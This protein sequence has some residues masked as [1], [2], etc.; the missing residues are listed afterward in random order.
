V[1]FLKNWQFQYNESTNDYSVF[2]A[3]YNKNDVA[4]ASDATV[5]IRITD[6][7]GNELYKATKNITKN[8]F[9]NYTSTSKG[10]QYLANIRIPKSDVSE[11]ISTSGIVYLKIYKENTFE[12][13]EVNCKALYCL[14][15]KPVTV[16]AERLPFEIV[17]KDY[18]GKTESTIVIEEVTFSFNSSLLSGLEISIAGAKTYGSNASR[19]IIGYKLYDSQG[20]MVK[21]GSITLSN[22]EQG[23]RFKDKTIT[24]YDAVPGESYVIRFSE[25]PY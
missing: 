18:S 17:L 21:T 4:I 2:F 25:N 9:G 22:L 7:S 16:T 23:D 11:G 3:F 6:E 13:D 10:N 1:L 5:E 15:V 8:Y 24:F 14:P 19:E 12:F 20:Y